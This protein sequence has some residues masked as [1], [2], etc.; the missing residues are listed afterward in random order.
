MEEVADC[1]G[2]ESAFDFFHLALDSN[3]CA[4]YALVNFAD[5]SLAQQAFKFFS[6]YQFKL[7]ASRNLGQTARSHIQGL[8][9][10]IRNF[11]EVSMHCAQQTMPVVIW[12]GQRI[13]LSRVFELEAQEQL[14]A[15]T[16]YPW[17]PQQSVAG[18]CPPSW[19]PTDPPSWTP[20]QLAVTHPS[21]PGGSALK[22]LRAN[23]TSV[24]TS[25]VAAVA[26][27][28]GTALASSPQIVFEDEAAV[29]VGPLEALP[30]AAP[31]APAAVVLA[32]AASTVQSPSSEGCVSAPP[33]KAASSSLAPQLEGRATA[34][35]SAVPWKGVAA[36]PG[37]PR[38]IRIPSA[39]EGIMEKMA[40]HF[41]EKF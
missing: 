21:S 22:K 34:L 20:G 32:T 5:A 38:E 41:G 40:R 17:P 4:T 39:Y 30:L 3:G 35:P 9:K 6:G 15:G 19:T 2:T 26:G 1:M 8:E 28:A 16:S 10:N 13:E 23:F 36:A 18:I 12:K 11:Q 29:V 31:S 14:A 24:P 27:T 33:A 25:F 7:Y 37:G